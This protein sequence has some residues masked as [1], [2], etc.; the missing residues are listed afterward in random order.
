[1]H[2]LQRILVLVQMAELL[3]TDWKVLDDLKNLQKS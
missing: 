3:H 2:I 1:M